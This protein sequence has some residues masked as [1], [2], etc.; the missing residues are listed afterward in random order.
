MPGIPF[1]ELAQKFVAAL[2]L[3]GATV[4]LASPLD[5]R[6]LMVSVVVGET[7]YRLEVYLWTITPGGKGRGRPRE[8]RIQRTSMGSGFVLKP[9]IKTIMG[10]WNEET[11]TFA[12]WD[13]RRHLTDSASPSSQIDL[14]TLENAH[15]HGMAT[16]HKLLPEGEEVAI[17]VQ[18]DYLLWYVENFDDIYECATEIADAAVLVDDT[19]EKQREFIDSGSDEGAQAR[20]HKLVE[21]VQTFRDARFRPQVLHA[22]GFRCA[23]TDIALRLVDAAHIVPV[24]DPTSTDH[25]NNGIALMPLLHRAYDS[26]LLGLLPG[27]KTA[28]NARIVQRLTDEKLHDGLPTLRQ[29]IRPVARMPALQEFYPPADYFLRGLKARGW[30]PDEIAKAQAEAG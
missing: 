18:H 8:R 10:G 20:R 6:P 12:F 19:P 4:I 27:G 30:L 5:R 15:L 23:L 26:G 13:V 1:P 17:A 3:A 28:I 25:P 29:L 16:Q 21:V 2:E 7:T 14:D 22:Y 24:S 9:G 11:G